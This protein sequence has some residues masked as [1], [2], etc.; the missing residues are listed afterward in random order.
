MSAAEA[1]RCE[2]SHRPKEDMQIRS[3]V[4]ASKDGTWGGNTIAKQMYPQKVVVKFS[5][6]HG[7]FA[8]YTLE[9]IGYKGV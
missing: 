9:H 8:T 5:D 7:D 3:V 1:E 2:Q 4:Y 6:K